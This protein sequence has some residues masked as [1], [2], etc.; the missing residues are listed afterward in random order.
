MSIKKIQYY[1]SKEY[2]PYLNLSAEEKLMDDYE[3]GCLIF[4]LWQNQNTIVIGKNQSAKDECNLDLMKKDNITLARRSSGGGAVFH[5]LGNINFTFITSKKDFDL[6]KQL[7]VIQKALSYYGIVSEFSGR[8]DLLVD[9]YK[10]SG[11]AYLNGKTSSLHHG[12]LLVDV[13]M[14]KLGAYLAQDK[15]KLQKHGVKSHRQRVK[16]IVDFNNSITIPSMI[17]SLKKAVVDIYKVPIEEKKLPKSDI[18]KYSSED[19]LY[20]LKVEGIRLRERFNYGLI[21]INLEVSNNRIIDCAIFS[22]I[23]DVAIIEEITNQLKQKQFNN[24]L[25]EKFNLENK[26]IEKDIKNLI[27]TKL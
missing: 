11:Q 21:D 8:N 12:T 1:L 2:S 9:G 6:H 25:L 13:D 19:W 24:S 23:M 22:D 17:A 20:R 7:E 14:G 15:T 16:N 5:D 27:R 4:Y 10:I 3:D 26:E 18:E